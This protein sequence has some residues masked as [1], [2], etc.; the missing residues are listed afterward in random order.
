MTLTDE[1]VSMLL[2]EA[3]AGW[4]DF[5]MWGAWEQVFDGM[6]LYDQALMAVDDD[7]WSLDDGRGNSRRD[8]VKR[9]LAVL[10]RHGLV[11]GAQ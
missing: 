4:P 8:P 5:G 1:Q 6:H 10:V 2:S 11:E 9:L 3:D 7:G